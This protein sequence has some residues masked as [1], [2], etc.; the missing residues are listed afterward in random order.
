MVQ[1]PMGCGNPG[2]SKPADTIY[3]AGGPRW[4]FVARVPP[5]AARTPRGSG[6]APRRRTPEIAGD[7]WRGRPRPRPASRDEVGV[8]SRRATPV[9]CYVLVSDFDY[10]LP[11][12]L[13]AQQPLPD[14]AASRLL[15]LQRAGGECHDRSF[16]DLH[17][18]LRP[19]DLLVLNNTR[20]FPARLY[21]HRSGARA[22]PVSPKNPA[23][24]AFL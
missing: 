18:L 4:R 3:G 1:Q 14:R 20:V 7:L 16:R 12:E 11:P 24:R 22:Q 17:G 9:I 2:Q 19:D 6:G 8:S 21:G 5:P 10:Q 23:A 15:H 13:I